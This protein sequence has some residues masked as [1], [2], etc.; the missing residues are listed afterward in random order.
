MVTPTRPLKLLG[1]KPTEAELDREEPTSLPVDQVVFPMSRPQVLSFREKCLVETAGMECSNL[2]ACA[3]ED[4]GP[5]FGVRNIAVVLVHVVRG[6][7]L[8]FSDV[9]RASFAPTAVQQAPCRS[10]RDVMT[11][12]A[13]HDG[14]R[15]VKLLFKLLGCIAPPFLLA[16]TFAGLRPSSRPTLPR[17]PK[18]RT[19]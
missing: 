8:E 4:K 10:A 6:S 2:H 15:M 9:R 11:T 16:A 17:N 7:W 12:A 13:Y 3:R 5:C 1:T 14:G 19:R 18:A